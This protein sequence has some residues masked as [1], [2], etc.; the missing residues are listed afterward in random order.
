MRGNFWRRVRAAWFFWKH[1]PPTQL[2]SDYWTN[3]DARALS[4]FL[5]CDPGIK[6]RHMWVEK[7]HMSAQRAIMEQA[8]PEYMAGV[9]WGIRS[10]VAFTDSLLMI[11]LPASELSELTEHQ[12]EGEF[13]SVN[14]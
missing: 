4:S 2:P 13:R 9:A 11:S 6:L 7:V 5:V 12:I 3:P 10:M 1:F 14:K 8:H